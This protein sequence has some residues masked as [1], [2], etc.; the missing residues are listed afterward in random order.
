MCSGCWGITMSSYT[1]LLPLLIAS[2]S[3]SVTLLPEDMPLRPREG[4][5]AVESLL[6]SALLWLAAKRRQMRAKVK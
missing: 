4:G 6:N 1:L 3:R 2:T 5:M